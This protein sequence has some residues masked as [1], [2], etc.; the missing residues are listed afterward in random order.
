[1]DDFRFSTGWSAANR[2]PGGNGDWG[3]S[4]ATA[5]ADVETKSIALLACQKAGIL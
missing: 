4:G 3:P 5:I 1:M 2:T